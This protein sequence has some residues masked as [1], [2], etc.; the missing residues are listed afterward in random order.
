MH[1]YIGDGQ[2]LWWSRCGDHKGSVDSPVEWPQIQ[3]R[4][5]SPGI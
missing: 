1:L 3:S 4:T 5:E 2:F